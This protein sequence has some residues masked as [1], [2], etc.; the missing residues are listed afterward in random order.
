MIALEIWIPAA[1]R[2]TTWIWFEL[3]QSDL[4]LSCLWLWPQVT[5]ELCYCRHGA[6]VGLCHRFDNVLD[7][8]Y[9]F[10]N[11][12]EL[13]YGFELDLPSATGLNWIAA[14]G[15]MVFWIAAT[16]LMMTGLLLRV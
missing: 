11:V 12:L 6:S 9:G 3:R 13:C 8:C 1:S 4:E 10:N 7:L 5:L 2:W 14:T 15:L 16:G